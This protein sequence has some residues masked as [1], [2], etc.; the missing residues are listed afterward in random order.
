VTLSPEERLGAALRRGG[1]P[2]A[3]AESCTG[4]LIAHRI[5]E[6]GGSSAYFDRGLVV[7]SNRAKT[8]LLG[9]PESLFVAHGAVSEQCAVAMLRG[10]FARSPARLAAAVTGIAGPSGGSA[11]KP[12]GTVWVAWGTPEDRETR[13]LHLQGT[14]SEI[15]LAAAGFVLDRLA[16]AAE[17][18]G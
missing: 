13:C 16:A 2:I 3:L 17:R 15:K 4:G 12:V 8:E 6:V 7:Y 18:A 14:R 9:V 5:T 11:D 1:G 10:I